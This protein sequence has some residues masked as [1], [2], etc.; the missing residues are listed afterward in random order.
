MDFGYVYLPY[1]FL[2]QENPHDMP[3]KCADMNLRWGSDQ[4]DTEIMHASLSAKVTGLIY[5]FI[6]LLAL[7][8]EKSNMS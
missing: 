7:L 4:K 1:L 6:I 8:I 3:C 2:I 5:A